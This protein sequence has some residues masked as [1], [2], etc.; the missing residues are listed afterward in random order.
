MRIRAPFRCFV[1][2]HIPKGERGIYARTEERAAHSARK[3]AGLRCVQGVRWG[4]GRA[5]WVWAV[6]SGKGTICD[7][8]TN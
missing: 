4:R 7:T 6:Q 5:L 3:D 1:G 8:Q 2:P